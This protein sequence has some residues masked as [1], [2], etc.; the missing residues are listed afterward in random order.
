ME[1]EKKKQIMYKLMAGS[2]YT[3]KRVDYGNHT[4]YKIPVSKINLDKTTL[5]SYKMISFADS[6]VDIEDGTKIRINAGY[7]SFYM[8]DKFNAIF[9]V[10]ITDFDIVTETTEEEYIDALNDYN[11]A[12]EDEMD[13]PF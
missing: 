8:K 4:F 6:E 3:V 12:L 5:E 13:V 10:V 9:T 7:E 1:E 2:V 11:K